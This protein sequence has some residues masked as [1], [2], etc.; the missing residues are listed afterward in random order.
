MGQILA[1]DSACRKRRKMGFNIKVST[2]GEGRAHA[3]YGSPGRRSRQQCLPS[4]DMHFESTSVPLVSSDV[5]TRPWPPKIQFDEIRY[6][7]Q[8]EE[9]VY[10]RASPRG[11]ENFALLAIMHTL[12]SVLFDSDNAVLGNNVDSKFATFWSMAMSKG[13][14]RQSTY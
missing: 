12:A 13:Y 2:G 7:H 5:A 10:L 11:L 3:E 8:G 4:L 9:Q 14:Q 1:W 6:L